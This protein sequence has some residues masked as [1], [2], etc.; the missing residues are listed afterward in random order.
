MNEVDIYFGNLKAG[1]DAMTDEALTTS[2]GKGKRLIHHVSGSS[3]NKFVIGTE[4]PGKSVLPDH[5]NGNSDQPFI[6]INA[7]SISK[8]ELLALVEGFPENTAVSISNN[9]K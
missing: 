6:H 7:D 9:I 8:A 4:R 3:Q 2:D 1:L 5:I